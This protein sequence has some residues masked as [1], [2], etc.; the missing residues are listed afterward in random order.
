MNLPAGCTDQMID[1]YMGLQ[2]LEIPEHNEEELQ[3]DNG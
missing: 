1:D 2:D 3:D